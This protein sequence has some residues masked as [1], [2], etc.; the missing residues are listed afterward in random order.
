[1]R[2]F[3]IMLAILVLFIVTLLAIWIFGGRQVSLFIDRFGTIEIASTQIK[4]IAYEGG[5]TSGTL[6]I[7]DLQL[8]LNDITPKIALSLGS[9]KDNQFALASGGNVFA[10]GPL[11]STAES[12]ADLATVPQAGDDAVF[13]TQHSALSWPTPF[14]LNFMTG[15][16]PSWKRHMYYQLRWKKPSG[17]KLEMLWRYEQY[18]YSAWGSGFTT[19]EGST[20]LIRI[21]IQR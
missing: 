1:M 15:Q 16:S 2:K 6:I 19:R 20:G 18:F 11:A 9:T 7:N 8:S 17:A 21:D 10:F 12:A 3:L 5:G 4:S 13:V 14:D